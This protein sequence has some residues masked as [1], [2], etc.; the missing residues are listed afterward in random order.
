MVANILNLIRTQKVGISF[1]TA[2]VF[3]S[4]GQ[5]VSSFIILNYLDPDDLGL[6]STLLLFETYSLFLQTGIINGLNRELP[7]Y[8]GMRNS[9]KA[10][11]LAAT[12]LYASRVSILLCLVVGLLVII[13]NIDSGEIYVITFVSVLAI[14]SI[15][16][17]ENYLTSTFRSNDSFAQLS[18]V[19]YFRGGFLI[20]STL[21]VILFGYTGYLVRMVAISATFTFA[22]HS[23]RPMKVIPKFSFIDF[24][25]ML[26]VGLPIFSLA[27]LFTTSSTIDRLI[28]AD[29][30]GFATVGYYSLGTMAIS[31][32]GVIPTSIANYIYPKM[33]FA[34]GRSNDSS[35]LFQ[36]GLQ[37]NLFVFL[38]LLPIATCGYFML[39]FL[40]E[41]IFPKYTPGVVA[42]QILLFSVIF[43]GASIGANV[44]WSL[45]DWY[46]IIVLQIGGS[47]LNIVAIYSGFY[48]I[49]SSIYGVSMGVLLSNIVYCFMANYLLLM[50]RNLNINRAL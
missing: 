13:L 34:F 48:L 16:Y 45:K 18:K 10:E 50:K 46:S 40:V 6:W 12:A 41:Y 7:F 28:L 22:L 8:L 37:I 19:Y 38:S 32:F 20:V 30:M 31:A 1:T 14:T 36:K 43:S 25:E 24:K 11:S 44:F 39:P 49:E 23:I 27:Y 5:I 2:S 29:K 3:N 33:S 4:I 35:F 9:A 47:F 15:K 42:A 21:L 26:K 17:Y